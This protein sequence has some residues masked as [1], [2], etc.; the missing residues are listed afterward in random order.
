MFFQR[1]S[2]PVS[3][4]ALSLLG[5]PLVVSASQMS[6]AIL[7]IGEF[8]GGSIGR[9]LAVTIGVF[10]AIALIVLYFVSRPVPV[11][12]RAVRPG[13]DWKKV[14]VKKRLPQ[15]TGD[16]IVIIGGAGSLGAAIADLLIEK[17][18]TNIVLFDAAPGILNPAH[19]KLTYIRGDVTSPMDVDRALHGAAAV[20][21]TASILSYSQ[22]LSFQRA[23][24]ERVNVGGTET[25]IESCVRKGVP[26]LIYVSSSH[27]NVDPSSCRFDIPESQPYVANAVNHYGPTKARAEQLVLRANG[28]SLQGGKVY[29]LAMFRMVVIDAAM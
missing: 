9:A 2:M 28:R 11:Q 12:L 8:T 21:H 4:C 7:E 13:V 1:F 18:E 5:L 25:V 3:L 22:R 14:N 16:K 24:S 15:A 17:G 26:Y 19:N 29:Q 6:S 10:G 23:L 27:V 20:Y